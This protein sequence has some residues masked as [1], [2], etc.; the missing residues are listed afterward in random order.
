ML[1]AYKNV[2]EAKP[3]K[4]PLFPPMVPYSDLT[5]FSSEFYEYCVLF[6][7]FGIVESTIRTF[8]NNFVSLFL[9]FRFKENYECFIFELFH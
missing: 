1:R 7:I 3:P 4:S 5:Q 8:I 6:K 2:W 9:N